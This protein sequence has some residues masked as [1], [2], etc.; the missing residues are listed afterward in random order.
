MGVSTE[1]G[2]GFG[3]N[4]SKELE[5]LESLSYPF[6]HVAVQ[7]GGYFT[8]NSPPSTYSSDLVKEWNEKYE[9]PHL[10]LATVKEL[11]ENIAKNHSGDIQT[12]RSAWPDWWTDGFGSAAIETAYARLNQAEFI[13]SQALLSMAL[14]SR[15]K[16]ARSFIR[17][18]KGREGCH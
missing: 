8:D 11:P 1:G 2:T 9:Y 4:L 14:L 6:D 13:S 5:K 12:F 16:I 3:E 15:L 7:F 17:T 18:D 10:K